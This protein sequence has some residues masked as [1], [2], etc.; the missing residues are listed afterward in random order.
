MKIK[1][2]IGIYCPKGHKYPKD[3]FP[4]TGIMYCGKCNENY[5]YSSNK[6]KGIVHKDVLWTKVDDDLKR[7]IRQAYL[8]GLN[9]GTIKNLNEFI[10]AEFKGD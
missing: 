7:V 8:I 1:I 4:S 5:G 6:K 10:E 9:N 2:E 3:Y